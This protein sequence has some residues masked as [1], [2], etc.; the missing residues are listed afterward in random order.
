LEREE[1]V[2][3]KWTPEEL[4]ERFKEAREKRKESEEAAEAERQEEAE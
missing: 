4:S 3:E 2:A 1:K